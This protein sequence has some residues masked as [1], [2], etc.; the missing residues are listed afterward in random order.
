MV[1]PAAIYAVLNAGGEGSA[2]W[3]IPMATDI[4]FALGILAVV[5]PGIP[6]ALRLFLLTLAIVDDI[7]AILV[8]AVFYAEG[9][10]P[11]WL[12]VAALAVAA[13]VVARRAGLTYTP[14]F[15]ALGCMT[16]LGLHEGG[17][18]ATLA[19]VA[20]GLLVPASPLL[21]RQIIERRSDELLD[22]FT[23]QAARSTTRMARQSVSQLEWL[24]S[25]LH[26][27]SSLVVVP[28]FA[29][30]N[31]GI[32]LDGDALGDGLTSSITLGV[33]LGLV[34][35]K[36]TGIVGGAWLADRLGW[37]TRPAGVTW[38]QLAGV[39]AL[40]GIGFTVSILVS[41]LAFDEAPLVDEAKVG[42]IAASV[43][44]SA[45]GAAFLRSARGGTGDASG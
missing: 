15:V 4:A 7:G 28:L 6:S 18:H 10:D 22:V 20:M 25:G 17:V 26:P 37:A 11:A 9:I 33:I 3:G 14:F 43:L 12:G 31:A 23:P 45:L 36:T 30:A 19:G 16:W 35:G 1:V 21:D 27:W 44:A 42:I 38:S 24:E 41:G 39:A 5:A 32:E 29:L 8:I 2:G 34:I 40:G 13:V